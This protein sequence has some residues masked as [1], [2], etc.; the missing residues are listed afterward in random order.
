MRAKVALL[1]VAVVAGLTGTSQAEAG[2]DI[3]AATGGEA[4]SADTAA[5][6]GTGAFTQLQ[7]PTIKETAPGQ[8]GVGPISVATPAGFEFNSSAPVRLRITPALP[9]V[10][11]LRISAS[12]S[13]PQGGSLNISVTP[14][15]GAITFYVCSSSA[16][17]GVKNYL[18]FRGA[19]VRPTQGTPLADGILCLADGSLAGV[20]GCSD[21][22]ATSFGRL[23]EIPGA[24]ASLSLSPSAAT[25]DFG[26]SQ[27]YTAS[28]ADKF[29]N[30]LGND[31]TATTIFS[32]APSGTC[33]GAVCTPELP[34]PHTVT[35]RNAGLTGTA[36]LDVRSPPSPEP[37]SI[38][39]EVDSGSHSEMTDPSDGR[40]LIAM[41]RND[42]TDV[43]VTSTIACPT[44][45]GGSPSGVTL[46]LNSTAY[47]MAEASPGIF[48]ATIP[49]AEVTDGTLSV[50][51]TCPGGTFQ[52]TVGTIELYD[53]S[54]II[55][56]VLPGS[57]SSS[58]FAAAEAPVVGEPLAGASV[59][60]YR[61]PS[62][63]P[64]TA[65]DDDPTTCQTTA[66]RPS[67]GF[68]QPPPSD[69]AL[70]EVV[71]PLGGLILP[72]VNPFIT[73]PAG[74]YG[75]DVAAGCY[76]IVVSADDFRNRTSSLVGVPP[77]VT[78]LNLALVGDVAPETTITSG[79]SS[80]TASA[81]A[82]FTFASSDPEATFAC[83]L[84][85]GASAACSSPV[86][87][88]GLAD[89][90][91]NFS[92]TSTSPTG[93]TDLTPAELAWVIDATRPVVT[94]LRPREHHSYVNDEEFPASEPAPIVVGFV[95]VEATTTVGAS[96]IAD[97]TFTVDGEPVEN[98]SYDPERNVYSF[99]FDSDGLGSHTIGATAKT[100]TGLTGS[101][102]TE[103]LA[104]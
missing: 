58:G 22:S 6:G 27:A 86:T 18:H 76:F 66:T 53:P 19:E 33:A 3:A 91:H 63:R 23:T 1:L 87:Y 103:V 82:T 90:G 69:P 100:G 74:L 40:L 80:P 30:S 56:Q 14:A 99:R 32:I 49:A 17:G 5:A 60:L 31:V 79:P 9:S 28:G 72:T 77:A 64:E 85:G 37:G 15:P 101:A 92:V 11:T 54:G 46:L 20:R 95:T 97:F 12:S 50:L 62:Y 81:D 73:N 34:V 65:A 84:D 39:T 52:H 2:V 48:S 75:W 71:D 8:I 93:R 78:D 88:T 42:R 4:I 10:N 89:G 13:C 67:E 7:E 96:G 68:N 47:P 55:S 70:S 43:V 94:I 26:D 59:L 41:P 21:T 29:G 61:V 16:A 104:A 83:A 25:I 98:V 38:S 51:Y 24:L 36:A 57:G 35:G 44:P 45:P 102:S